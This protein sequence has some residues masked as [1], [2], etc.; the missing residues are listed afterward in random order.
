MGDTSNPELIIIRGALSINKLKIV[1]YFT[2]K[3]YASIS[4]DYYMYPQKGRG[5]YDE[6]LLSDYEYMTLERTKN[7]LEAKYPICLWSVNNRLEDLNKYLSLSDMA[8]I[9]V[10]Y[11]EDDSPKYR[12]EIPD[13]VMVKD[14]K[15]RQPYGE[16]KRISLSGEEIIIE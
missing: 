6:N 11:T 13:H 5:R 3:Y 8:D 2:R 9:K 7:L 16:E 4:S 1:E 14:R 12:S 10:Y 15:G